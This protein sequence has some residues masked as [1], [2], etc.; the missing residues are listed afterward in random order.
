M[1]FCL[2]DGHGG[3]NVAK[4]VRDRLPE[5]FF[6]YLSQNNSDI[7]KTFQ[8]TF[9]KIESELTFPKAQ[10]MGTTATILYL[11]KDE[12]SSTK[13][14]YCANV[15]DSRGLLISNDKVIRISFD[16]KCCDR[17]E[18]ERI[19]NSGGY[20]V[21]GRLSG[22]INLSRTFG[23]MS[24][25]SVGLSPIP[26]TFNCE[27]NKNDKY[28]ILASDGVWD[29]ISDI[30]IYNFSKLAENATQLSEKI[31]KKAIDFGSEDNISCLTIRI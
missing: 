24:L 31:I 3:S 27:L 20:V 15:G 10:F 18:I 30:D 25:K 9:K 8:E 2:F 23:D 14:L 21:N 12:K 6:A 29:V 5:V 26:F 4:F 22:T 17:G 7:Q 11:Y 19:N 16:H 28:I 13:K 1:L